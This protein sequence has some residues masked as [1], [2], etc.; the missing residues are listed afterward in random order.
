MLLC[1]TDTNR[2]F[3]RIQDGYLPTEL[4]SLIDEDL[5]R[6]EAKKKE[7]ALKKE[8]EENGTT[9]VT[10]T[11]VTTTTTTKTETTVKKKTE[12]PTTELTTKGETKQEDHSSSPENERPNAPALEKLDTCL[13]DPGHVAQS[14]LTRLPPLPASPAGDNGLPSN[15]IEIAEDENSVYLGLRVY[16]NKDTPVVVVGQLKAEILQHDAEPLSPL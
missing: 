16:T 2:Y 1:M 15:R 8:Q 13:F 12:A 14:P 4:S 11:T 5:K 9:T 10:V 7:E 3:F 6:F